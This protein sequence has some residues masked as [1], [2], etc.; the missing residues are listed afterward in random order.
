MKKVVLTFFLIV[1]AFVPS[2]FSQL[3]VPLAGSA[4]EKKAT[5]RFD[6]F[7]RTELFFGRNRAN[8]P[9]ITEEEFADF[10]A[11]AVTPAFPDGLTVLDGI[12]QFRDSSGSIV[13]EKA[14]VLILLYPVNTRR[15]S[16]RSIERIRE[17]YKKR[18][19]QQS[20][21]RADDLLP[22]QLSF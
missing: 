6:A 12:G 17:A 14:K 7:I 10:L 16:S 8:G 15:A 9:E 21:L 2:A 20:V 3:N 13:R 22:V 11:Q 18:F 19:E 1:F 5:V 4:A